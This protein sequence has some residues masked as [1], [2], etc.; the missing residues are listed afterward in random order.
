MSEKEKATQ[1]QC[2]PE[3]QSVGQQPEP[4][5]GTEDG[6]EPQEPLPEVP[7]KSQ[8]QLLQE[9]V[10]SL[11]D[12]LLRVRAEYDNF[13]KR[14]Q[15]EKE[16]I[17]PQATASTVSQFLPVLDA[18]ERAVEAP[19]SDEEFKK[20]VEMILHNF[21]EILGKLGVEEFGQAGDP[22][23]PDLHNAVAHVEDETAEA[24][25]IVEVFQRGYK[26]GDRVVRHAMVKVAN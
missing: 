8:E 2:P 4:V 18:F 1:E 10:D 22:F 6:Q 7:E 19:C 16:N 3:E 12:Q 17:Y 11:N 24:N 21:Q 5:Q 9:E 15:R 23:N 20:G 25:V 26:M 14:S 13:R